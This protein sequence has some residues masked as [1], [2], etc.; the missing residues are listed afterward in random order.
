MK[1]RLMR[2]GAASS[3]PI[4][5]AAAAATNIPAPP[6]FL[7]TYRGFQP[8]DL[9]VFDAFDVGTPRPAD[10]FITDFMGV[11]T[12]AA[13]LADSQRI[14]AGCVLGPPV[15]GDYHAEAIEY[16]GLYK[17]VLSASGSYRIAELGAG[18]GPF[19][20]AGAAAARMRGINDI[21]MLG[22][23]SDPG[24]FTSM[25]THLSD[26]D[27][28]PRDHVMLQAAVGAE[29][30]TALFP[31][32]TDHANQWG[33]RPALV[34]DDGVDDRDQQFLGALMDE[35]IEVD[36]LGIDGLLARAPEWD[37]V[38]IDIQGWEVQVVRAGLT[39]LSRRARYLIVG[40]HS[41]IIDAELITLLRDAGWLLEH[42]KPTQWTF[43]PG[44]VTLEGMTWADGTQV[45]RN[46]RFPGD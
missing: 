2:R 17:S 46:P 33:A 31:R 5:A 43:V 18:W 14:Y 9:W 23:E 19:L 21:L 4:S 27:F 13:S 3:T 6:T 41:R 44:D 20:V 1:Q 16:I 40:T 10:G 36:V 32:V 12:R 15:P 34:G 28:D 39:E 38:H 45:W 7:E 22:V 35:T 37:C 25:E 29:D 11:R 30:G 8:D 26:N 24:H 42:E